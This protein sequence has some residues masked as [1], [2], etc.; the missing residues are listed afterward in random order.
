MREAVFCCLELGKGRSSALFAVLFDE[1]LCTLCLH[2]RQ[3]AAFQNLCNQAEDTSC[4]ASFF[5]L[6]AILVRGGPHSPVISARKPPDPD[7]GALQDHKKFLSEQPAFTLLTADLVAV[8]HRIQNVA[9]YLPSV[10]WVRSNSALWAWE[11]FGA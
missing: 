5:G 7:L 3:A 10:R 6:L 8:D 9:R 2:V 1:I 4:A 11:R